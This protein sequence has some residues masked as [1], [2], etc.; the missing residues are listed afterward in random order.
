MTDGGN[1]KPQLPPAPTVAQL[2]ITMNLDTRQV[3]LSGPLGDRFLCY[4]MLGLA[5][6]AISASARKPETSGLVLPP[7]GLRLG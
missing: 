4:G 5:G 1:G 7:P 3:Q 2:I 6:E